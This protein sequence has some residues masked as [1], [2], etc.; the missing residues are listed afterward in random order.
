MPSRF[1]G[2]I[3]V[4][5]IFSHNLFQ[6][7]SFSDIPILHFLTSVLLHPN[8]IQITP[9]FSLFTAYPLLPWLGILLT[10]FAAG[11]LF[12]MSKEKRKNAFWKIGIGIISFFIIIRFINIYGDP[13]KWTTQKSLWFTFLSFINATKYPPS[14]MFTLLFLGLTF[15]TLSISENVKNKFTEI[16]MT[17]GRVPLFYFVIHLFIIHAFMF[18]ILYLQGFGSKDFLFGAFKNGRPESGGGVNLVYI[19]LIWI[20]IVIFLYPVCKWYGN[21]KAKHTEKRFLRYL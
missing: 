6:G 15:L 9:D 20:A 21:Y 17:Y 7:F 12:E 13:S 11:E 14:L 18:V 16:L 2:M 5:I 10:G 3:G 1:I 4:L 8:L 19:Y